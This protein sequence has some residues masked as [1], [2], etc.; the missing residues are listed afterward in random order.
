[1]VEDW[2]TNPAKEVPITTVEVVR[3]WEHTPAVCPP[4]RGSGID[5]WAGGSSETLHVKTWYWYPALGGATFTQAAMKPKQQDPQAGVAVYPAPKSP[6]LRVP[7]KRT[8][9]A[10]W[11]TTL[12]VCA[13]LQNIL[14]GSPILPGQRALQ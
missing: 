3:H 12:S 8:L 6:G 9:H 4:C 13:L 2:P 5:E 11:K 7:P 1:M 14:A 10:L